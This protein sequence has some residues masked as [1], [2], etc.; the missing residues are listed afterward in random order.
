MYK[1]ELRN[2]LLHESCD[3]MH[4]FYKV[5]TQWQYSFSKLINFLQ[6]SY[7]RWLIERGK[8]L[9]YFESQKCLSMVREGNR[10]CCGKLCHQKWA[11]LSSITAPQPSQ[12]LEHLFCSLY[13][14]FWIKVE[15]IV[16][17][18][19]DVIWNWSAPPPRH[20]L[21]HFSAEPLTP[22]KRWCY[23]WTIPAK[24]IN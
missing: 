4:W 21:H 22:L 6:L 10:A 17:F 14:R 7:L 24:W 9:K 1:I 2:F 8:G 19:N 13:S 11:N 5:P 12:P 3:K 23:F 18:K 20:L 16:P 15:Q